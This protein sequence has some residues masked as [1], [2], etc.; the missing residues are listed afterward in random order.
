MKD[1]LTT[2]VDRLRRVG[3]DLELA[4]NYPW[5]YIDSINGARVTEKFMANHGFTIAFYPIRAD[6]QVELTDLSE[7][8]KL[9]RKYCKHTMTPREKAEEL[10]RYMYNIRSGS[11]S[12]ITAHWAKM[13]SLR[14]CNEVLG[15]MGSD[16]GHE[17]WQE[18]K[19]EIEKL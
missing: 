19:K 7:I 6:K 11:H 5:I 12:M 1:K 2:L 4:G 18:V 3:V 17:F 16:R 13:A 15:Y 8:F 9:I 14:C 10:F